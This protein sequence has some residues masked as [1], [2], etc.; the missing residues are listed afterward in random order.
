MQT[1][2]SNN[3]GLKRIRIVLADDHSLTRAGLRNFLEHYQDMEIVGEAD[4]GSVAIVMVQTAHP[5]VVVM[6]ISMPHVN[7]I[8][9]T[10]AIHRQWPQVKVIALST[11][12]D[13]AHVQAMLK[14]GASGFVVKDSIFEDLP[15]GIR[16]VVRGKSYFSRRVQAFN[17]GDQIDH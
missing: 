6:D 7:G 4:D 2:E 9:A 8:D 17:L 12:A 1:V 13:R 14:A 10:K 16:E 11:H 15:L 3:H 5:D